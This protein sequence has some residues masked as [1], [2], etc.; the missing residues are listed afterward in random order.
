MRLSGPLRS[1]TATFLLALFGVLGT[2]VPSHHHEAPAP[3]EGLELLAAD[4]H[5][6]GTE[7]VEQKERAPSGGPHIATAHPVDVLLTPAT[8][9]P[10]EIRG[11][12][13]LRPTERAPPPGAPRA[14][15]HSV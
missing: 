8:D 14:P 5:S 12:D 7:L 2:G 4:H 13:L 6:H 1:V 9:A 3:N 15:P 11:A 10:V